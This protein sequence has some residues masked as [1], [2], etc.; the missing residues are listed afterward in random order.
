MLTI[1]NITVTREEVWT[2]FRRTHE[3]RLRERYH[4]ILLLLDGKTCPEIAQ[5]LYRDEDTIRLWSHAFNEAGLQGLVR[6]SIPGR[7]A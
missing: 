6:A 2:A 4:C 3:V 7:P 5:W 1:T